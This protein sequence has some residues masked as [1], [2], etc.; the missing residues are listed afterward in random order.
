MLNILSKV[1]HFKGDF[2]ETPYD[3]N[4]FDAVYTIEAA[5]HSYNREKVYGEAFRVLKP[6]GVFGVYEWAMTDKYDPNNL[7]HKEIKEG[8]EVR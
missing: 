4:S 7:E 2:N 5:C 8:V 3:D 1:C 6:G